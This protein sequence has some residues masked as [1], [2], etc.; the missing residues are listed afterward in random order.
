MQQGRIV[1]EIER[2]RSCANALK[3][4]ALELHNWL[5]SAE[6]I[7]K[8]YLAT[9]QGSR[10]TTILTVVANEHARADGWT[11]LS[12]ARQRAIL[13]IPEDFARM[14]R[15]YGEGSLQQL[16]TAIDLFDL[17]TEHTD[18]GGARTLYRLRA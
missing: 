18:A 14:K 9:L 4:A 7:R 8:F 11:P 12:T 16:V 15:K 10:L 13:L 5:Q 1:T 3:E 2:Y 17:R 6:G